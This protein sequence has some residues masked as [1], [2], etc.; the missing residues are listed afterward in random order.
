[1]ILFEPRLVKA[2]FEYIVPDLQN[3]LDEV[4]DLLVAGMYYDAYSPEPGSNDL[5][6]TNSM[7]QYVGLLQLSTA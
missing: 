5:T 7:D 3:L 6:P 4:R 2:P 1:M